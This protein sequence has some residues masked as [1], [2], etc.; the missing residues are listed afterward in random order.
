[1]AEFTAVG[2]GYV[3]EVGGWSETGAGESSI[4]CVTGGA[5]RV[6]VDGVARVIRV[7]ARQTVDQSAFLTDR[8]VTTCCRRTHAVL[9]PD[10]HRVVRHTFCTYNAQH[11]KGPNIALNERTH[12]RA[13]ERHLSYGITQCYL[14][15]DR[16]ERA[17]P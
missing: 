17:P 9:R 3:D 8:S 12:L 13:T 6:I 4:E 5:V 16:G 2:G 10:L 15:P 7:A 1:M 11:F 14:P